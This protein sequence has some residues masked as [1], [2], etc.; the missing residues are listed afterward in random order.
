MALRSIVFLYYKVE[1]LVPN[2]VTSAQS[3][4]NQRLEEKLGLH[5]DNNMLLGNMFN[6]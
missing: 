4:L 1:K 3:R 5:N 2:C 6:F